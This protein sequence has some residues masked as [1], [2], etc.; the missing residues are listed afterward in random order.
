MSAVKLVAKETSLIFENSVY[1]FI[2]LNDNMISMFPQSSLIF[3]WV[4]LWLLRCL[5]YAG[6]LP[7]SGRFIGNYFGDHF[8]MSTH[9]LG[10]S[11]RCV[12]IEY[13]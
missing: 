13:D 4:V 9:N 1:T 11:N 6:K 7:Q 2:Y 5:S 10:M 12:K 3:F 8:T